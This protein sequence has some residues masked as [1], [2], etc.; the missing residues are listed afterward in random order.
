[1]KKMRIIII[2]L[3]VLLVSI[4]IAKNIIA[5]AAITAGVKAITGLRLSMGSMSV[6]ILR[7]LIDIKNLELYNPPEFP[8][9]LMVN[10][11]EIYVDYDLGAF[12]NKRIHL[13]E[14]RLNLK[15]LIVVNNERGQLNLNA[16]K[17]V[18]AKREGKPAQEAEKAKM[19]EIQIDKLDL[20]IGKV[21]YKDYS[22]A[23]AP[24]VKEFNVD[25]DEH[26]ENITDPNALVK[27]IVNKALAKT[28]IRHLADFALDPIKEE[29]T[30]TIESTTKAAKEVT[31]KTLEAAKELGE[32][33]VQTL[34]QTV[35][36][37]TETIKDILPI[38]E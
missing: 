1:M 21:I 4:T 7:T 3:L 28:A 30:K 17:V 12:L 24:M 11:P 32:E 10:M 37:A 2:V 27:L 34:E 31:E 33:A 25:I 14:L 5:K 8:E 19:P 23:S 36:E 9:R 29:M 38:G 20:K 18:K 35:E 16:L 26:Y 22:S 13:E 6:G 15:E